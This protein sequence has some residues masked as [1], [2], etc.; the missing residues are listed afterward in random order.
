MQECH[1]ERLLYKT[2]GERVLPKLFSNIYIVIKGHS[3]ITLSQNEQNMDPPSPL[4]C[5]CLILV[6]PPPPSPFPS[7][8][9]NAHP[10]I[11]YH[12]SIFL[13]RGNSAI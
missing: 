12:E 1:N 5:T 3:I 4:V 13:L 2:L 6:S 9:L 8:N 7:P 11:Y 10:N